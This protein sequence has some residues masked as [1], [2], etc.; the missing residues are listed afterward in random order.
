MVRVRLPI[1]LPSL[2]L[3]RLLLSALALPLLPL[4]SL[5]RLAPL[6]ILLAGAPKQL[7]QLVSG[8][9]AAPALFIYIINCTAASPSCLHHWPP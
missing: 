5:C 4:G 2:L 7:S 1:T 9:A 8:A 6:L 3:V